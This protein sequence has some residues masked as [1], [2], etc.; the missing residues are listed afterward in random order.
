MLIRA[1]LAAIAAL[2]IT[3]PLHAGPRILGKS[4][5]KSLVCPAADTSKCVQT[6]GNVTP[7]WINKPQRFL[8]LDANGEPMLWQYL[9]REF[10]KSA[11]QTVNFCGNVFGTNPLEV[12]AA[13]HPNQNIIDTHVSS[14]FVFDRKVSTVAGAGLDIDIDAAVA[15][16]GIPTGTP[17]VAAAAALKAAVKRV[18]NSNTTMT[19]TYRFVTVNPSI[20]AGLRAVN[21]PPE[22]QQCSDDL[23]NSTSSIITSLTGVKIETSTTSGSLVSNASMD[24]DAKLNGVL[25]ATQIAALK[26][27]FSKSVEQKWTVAFAPTFQV[28]SIAGF[29]PS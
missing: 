20:V 28:L 10:T 6:T 29:N 19:G 12:Y 4:E 24:F 15:A 23:K 2:I 3:T 11:S 9:G 22:F 27:Q 25:D 21:P 8:P 13:N 26:T 1:S 16:A 7:V 14:S 5:K 17:Q 18:K